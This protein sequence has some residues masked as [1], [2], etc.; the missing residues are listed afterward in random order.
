MVPNSVY[1]KY[2]TFVG[3]GVRLATVDPKIIKITYIKSKQA[4]KWVSDPLGTAISK[5]ATGFLTR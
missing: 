1:G 2:A 3:F 4:S 5:Q